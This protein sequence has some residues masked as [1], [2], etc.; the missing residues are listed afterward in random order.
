MSRRTL[1][2]FFSYV[3]W[4][5]LPIYWKLV[6][7][8]SPLY[9]LSTRIVWVILIGAVI[10]TLVKRWPAVKAVFT[11]RKQFWLTVLAGVL[12]CYNW[13]I[14]IYLIDAGQ[15]LECSLGY[16]T[17]PLMMVLLGALVFKEK[18]SLGEKLAVL[19]AA[20]GITYMFISTGVFPLLALS[21]PLSF[22]IYG[23]IK[24]HVGL[25][26]NVSLFVETLPLV[27]LAL[28]F[29]VYAEASGAGAVGVYSGFEW[30]L[31]PG[32]GLV[33]F[34]PMLMFNYGV[35]GTRYA[36]TGMLQYVSPTIHFFLS[37]FLYGEA[38]TTAHLV[39]FVCV[40]IGVI[41]FTI[42]SLRENRRPELP[43]AE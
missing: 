8:L 34:V 23:M 43:L 11:N 37:V 16:Y 10:L 41:L 30:L 15:V 1:T 18:L 39:T 14:Y 29:I 3:V 5:F 24:K 4:G 21:M 28:A 32:C 19:L 22:A 13:G 6:G 20:I 35:N 38:F 27:P 17:M 2:V 12:V 26:G 31:L 36:L 42:S 25:E 9:V 40:W 33:T 7:N